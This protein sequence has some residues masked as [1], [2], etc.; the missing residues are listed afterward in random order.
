MS[1]Q[2]WVNWIEDAIS[3][4]YIKHYEYKNFFNLKE[5]GFG[6]FAKVLRA[7]WKNSRNILVIKSINEF[8]AE[9]I[10][11]EVITL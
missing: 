7:S 3:K 8:T 2:D 9:K 11:Y 10:V 5:I 1:K 4:K 6:G